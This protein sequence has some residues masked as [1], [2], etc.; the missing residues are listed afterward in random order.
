MGRSCPAEP[1]LPPHLLICACLSWHHL[2]LLYPSPNPLSFPS[3]GSPSTH[4]SYHIYDCG[5]E[6]AISEKL[7]QLLPQGLNV[8]QNLL[9]LPYS[10]CGPGP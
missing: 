5:K 9:K 3:P 6:Q 1:S 4:L 2:P 8:P 7:F 10:S